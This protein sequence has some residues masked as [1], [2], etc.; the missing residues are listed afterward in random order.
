MAPYA[1][2]HA[3]SG[4]SFLDGASDPEELVAQAV[5]LELSALALTDHNGLYGV[6][7]FAT[8]ARLLGLPTGFGA[9][10]TIGS[11]A[12]RTGVPDPC[13]EHLLVLA[14]G[15]EGYGRLSA[16]IADAHLARGSKG[17]LSLTIEALAAAHQG[18]W[19][20]LTGCRKGAVNQALLSGGPRAARR[21]LDQ[22]I[23]AFGRDQVAVELWD[24]GHPLD[25]S[26]NDALAE[27]AIAANVDLV[28]TN[29][30]HYATASSFAVANT[31]SAIR[32]Q[33]PLSEMDGW[34][35]SA[36]TA[37]LRSAAEQQRRFARWPGV[38][39]RAADIGQACA[40]DLSLVAPQLPDFPV[41]QG[42][43]E[44]T[45][46]AHLVE[47]GAT[48]KYGPRHHADLPR[49]WV[50]IDHELSVIE[51]LQFAGYFLVVWDITEFCRRQ[52]IYC[53][54]RGSA[55]NSAVCFSLGITNADAVRLN[56][57]FE[58]FLSAARDG[59][60]DID[61]DIES[62]RREEVLQ[63]VYERYGRR[64]A[65]QVA[66][67]ITYRQR[68]SIRDVAAALG[69]SAEVAGTWGTTL[70]VVRD[71]FGQATNNVAVS[72]PS[73]VPPLVSELA[74][75]LQH[76]P[77][78]L[79]IHSAGM[80][81][82]DRP[83]VEV[84]PVEWA[85]MPG[86]TVL[87]WDKDDCAAIGLVKFDLLGLG[88]LEALHA[89]VDLV[90]LHE[91]TAVD[92]G[93]LPQE[94]AVYDLLCRADTVGVFQV[95]SRAQMATLPRLQPRCFYDLVIEVA[96]IRPGP[97]QGRAVNPYLRRRTGEE[98]VTYPHP[99][100]EPI[101]QRTLGV[102][103][104]Q[105]QLMEMAVA[106]A[107]FTPTE[108]DEL[109]SAMASKRSAE[110]MERLRVRFYAGMA[111]KSVTGTVADDLYDALRAFANFG[112]PE[113]HSVS[114]AHLVYCS[115]WFKVHHGAA[116]TVA[117]LNAQPMGFW[118]EQS[119]LA[120]AKRHGIFVRRPHVN[121][122]AEQATLEPEGDGFAIRLGLRSVR[123]LGE[124]AHVVAAGAPWGSLEDLVARA[125]LN[126]G[127][128]ENLAT[129]GA[130]DGISSVG[131]RGQNHRRRDLVWAAGSAAQATRDRL[132]GIVVG[133]TAPLLAEP[134]P[135]ELVADDLWS[136]GVTPQITA[137][138]LAREDL[139]RRGVVVAAALLSSQA[140]RV[141]V[142]GVVTHRQHPE[143]AH[144]A[145]FCNLEDETGHV[146]VVFSKG[147]WARWRTIARHAPILLV[148]GRLERGR[149]V[150]NVV[151][152]HVERYG[153]LSEA[154]PSRDFR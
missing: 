118:S 150:V 91:G 26:R 106:I 145:V 99:L 100:L 109:R 60:P 138:E 18:S 46:L 16:T 80:V 3:H 147:A 114:F 153:G 31:L 105:E 122:S 13:G 87:Q 33:R 107:G 37:Q 85:R 74:E 69:Y 152:E 12:P 149:G 4:F 41:P 71:A 129:A 140:E 141:L 32:A 54:G 77:R 75:A 127:Q 22:L 72:P 142:C 94:E 11:G 154:P 30:V 73:P 79:G 59:P 8:A 14:R 83:I 112:F 36:P 39:D 90:A 98:P 95:E 124:L 1:E 132:P 101:L 55:A 88:M 110:K 134:T 66:N 61:V 84:C 5:R 27:I 139:R 143:T 82:C 19:Q 40:L 15:P 130:L 2:L 34:L 115:A 52:N 65:A 21:A 96:L 148:R 28:A 120:D 64:H 146:N 86:R 10:V 102:P 135:R 144:G 119:L 103:L 117:L 136:L 62:G 9:E 131:T 53:Q 123:G 7:R 128:L 43:S 58:R 6:V 89:M 38:V 63:Y 25:S 67:V 70:E 108:A 93:A 24:H 125:G 76:R 151:A 68:S 137:M 50:Q 81:I 113:S 23:E 17:E 45:Y 47:V 51:G 133:A 56:L 44:Q 78:H 29:N 104:F 48:K 116:F 97:I 111:E 92:L 35:A 126:A 57:F 121:H 49:A 20:I 42:F